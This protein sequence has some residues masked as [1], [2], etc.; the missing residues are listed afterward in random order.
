[1]ASW[2]GRRSVGRILCR[3]VYAG[4]RGAT[5][6]RCSP[7]S[8]SVR[9]AFS[10]LTGVVVVYIRSSLALVAVAKTRPCLTRRSCRRETVRGLA[11]GTNGGRGVG[12]VVKTHLPSCPFS[13]SRLLSLQRRATLVIGT[14]HPPL[15]LSLSLFAAEE[16][17][18]LQGGIRNPL[19]PRFPVKFTSYPESSV[20]PLSLRPVPSCVR[21]LLLA[22]E[23]YRADARGEN[24][25]EECRPVP[26]IL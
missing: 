8:S 2:I 13:A 16:P 15:F 12:R 3:L 6:K 7:S 11:G 4:S 17:T 9:P 1:M 26:I 22:F 24:R 23:R 10:P 18:F 25:H 20:P 19:D 5:R 14:R 21:V